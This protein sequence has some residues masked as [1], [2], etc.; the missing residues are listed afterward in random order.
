MQTGD[1]EELT[2]T[3]N[4]NRQLAKYA[5]DLKE[6]GVKRINVSLD[7]LDAQKFAAITRWGRF[8]QV[9]DGIRAAKSAGLQ[10]K[11]NAVALKGVND[12]EFDKLIGWCGE[13]GF[14]LTLIEVMPL[15]EVGSGTRVDQYL[16][17]SNGAGGFAQALDARRKRLQDRRTGALLHRARDRTA[18]SASSRR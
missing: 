17:L 10:V 11:L 3:T 5:R 12:G 15:G 14:D 1:L 7:T 6:A 9:M 2:L 13:E 4:G 18:G 16:P 8:D